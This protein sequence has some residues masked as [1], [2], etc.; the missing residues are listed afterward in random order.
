MR[1]D[2]L[3]REDD[4]FRRRRQEEAADDTALQEFALALLVDVQGRLVVLGED[5]RGQPLRECVGGATVGALAGVT[6]RKDQPD[7]VVGVGRLQVE[8]TVRADHDVVR[9]RGH[10]GKAVHPVQ[11]VA[12]ALERFQVQSVGVGPAVVIDACY[13]PRRDAR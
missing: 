1:H 12:G 8:E 2:V 9:R 3:V 11:A 10:R 4:S 6:L 13:A 7:D 5:A